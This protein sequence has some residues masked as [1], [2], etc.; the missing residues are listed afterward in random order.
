MLYCDLSSRSAFLKYYTHC[1]FEYYCDPEFFLVAQTVNVVASAF[2]YSLPWPL[3]LF[4]RV[5]FDYSKL[6]LALQLWISEQV[7]MQT[8]TEL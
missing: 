2:D 4:W 6:I 3:T 5:V 1:N 8:A 7:Y